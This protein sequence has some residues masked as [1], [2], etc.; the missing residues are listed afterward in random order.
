MEQHRLAPATYVLK[1]RLTMPAVLFQVGESVGEG[2]E[3]Q[4]LQHRR[5]GVGLQVK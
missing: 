3:F 4:T 5:K 1:D 2:G